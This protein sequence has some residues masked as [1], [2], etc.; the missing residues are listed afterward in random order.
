MLGR[1]GRGFKRRVLPVR[2]CREDSPLLPA[3]RVGSLVAL[4]RKIDDLTTA[5]NKE[6]VLALA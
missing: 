1:M 4:L 3:A 5:L 6:I 2:C